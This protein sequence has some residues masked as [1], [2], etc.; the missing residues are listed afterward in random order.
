MTSSSFSKSIFIRALIMF[1]TLSLASYALVKE[2]YVAE[3]I[4]GPLIIYQFFEYYRFHKKAQ[5]EIEQFVESV[6]YRDFSRHFDVK[7]AP[8][9]LQPFRSGFNQINST[10]KVISKEKET[11]YLHLKTILEI[12]DT[13]ILSYETETG[14]ILWMN[15]S[16]KNLLQIPYL[17]TIHSLEKRNKELYDQ[18]SVL[19]P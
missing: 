4:L 8:S 2:W 19:A 14:E 13:G 3:I 12:V 7:Q 16:F 11:Q 6:H 5:V 17:K 9:E 18:I 1:A 15:E 10:F